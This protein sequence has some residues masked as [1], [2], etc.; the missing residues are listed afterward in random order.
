LPWKYKEAWQI[1]IQQHLDAGC[2]HPSTLPAF[3]IPKSN[4]NVLPQWVNDYQKLNENTV[5]DSHP[6]PCIDD[7]LSDCTKGKIWATI[8]MT[9]SFFQMRMH[10]DHVHLI[11]VMTLLGPADKEWRQA[12]EMVGK[13]RYQRCLD[14]FE[15]LI[16]A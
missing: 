4:P 12:A 16:V 10:P 15:G 9:N 13:R 1:L 5:T 11:A 8:D 6:L 14:L 7:I 2:I 3:I